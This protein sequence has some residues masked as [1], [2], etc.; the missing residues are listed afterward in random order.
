[1]TFADLNRLQ[2]PGDRDALSQIDECSGL[3]IVPAE[4][5]LTIDLSEM[6]R[7]KRQLR[8]L[9]GQVAPLLPEDLAWTPPMIDSEGRVTTIVARR[10][11]LDEYVGNLERHRGRY[12]NACSEV[13]GYRFGYRTP[14]AIRQA[15]TTHAVWGVSL[16]LILIGSVTIARDGAH[17]PSDEGI[18]QA[19]PGIVEPAFTRPTLA[20]TVMALPPDLTGDLM[21]AA[22]G[23]ERH[24]AIVVELL[25][26]DP[27]ALRDAIAE[28]GALS[29]F[30]ETGQTRDAGG[31]YLVRYERAAPGIGSATRTALPI[32]AV[33][34]ADA[35]TQAQRA[36]A[37]YAA[38]RVVEMSLSPPAPRADGVVEL[39]VGFVGPQS[40]VLA[41]A[42]QIESGT[43]PMRIAEW[44][45]SPVPAGVR[46]M[47]VIVV[48]WTAQP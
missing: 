37:T 45:M 32:K 12:L 24:G 6:P 29:N 36:L 42:D 4:N 14:E 26:P 21:V 15:F 2:D 20:A 33:D 5:S 10:R 18:E 1:M 31:G 34:A 3:A 17:G 25:T 39:D 40:D 44:T 9:I 43:M 28:R 30:R 27:D 13:G 35:R 48:P 47:A 46:L 38:A 11:W 19:L 8:R 23:R 16:A 41:L 22:I 7:S